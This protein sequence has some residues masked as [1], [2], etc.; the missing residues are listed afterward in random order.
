[1]LGCLRIFTRVGIEP[2]VLLGPDEFEM[3]LARER[4]RADRA[5]SS[6]A[7]LVLSIPP[8]KRAVADLQ[9]IGKAFLTR[10][11]ATDSIGKMEDGRIGIV[12]PDTTRDQAEVLATS[13]HET[14]ETQGISFEFSVSTYSTD[15]AIGRRRQIA[16]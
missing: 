8:S 3:Q 16:I 7:L 15:Q 2:T 6:F 1:M 10:Q 11:R 5:G 9:A 14:L 4:S 12:L 13:L